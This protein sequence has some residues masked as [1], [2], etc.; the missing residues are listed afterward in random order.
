[1]NSTR[2]LHQS[3]RRRWAL[4]TRPIHRALD[5]A[6]SAQDLPSQTLT[7]VF[8]VSLDDF[9]DIAAGIVS[10]SRVGSRIVLDWR[11]DKPDWAQS[12]AMRTICSFEPGNGERVTVRRAADR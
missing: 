12:T 11:L 5:A 4:I 7:S 1:L 8:R 10:L 3:R 2:S 9:R 6:L